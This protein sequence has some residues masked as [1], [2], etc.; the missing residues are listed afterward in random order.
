MGDLTLNLL[1]AVIVLNVGLS[2][3]YGFY[4]G[5]VNNSKDAVRAYLVD[6]GA[7]T[8]G[9]DAHFRYM[10]SVL[11]S[12]F[13][14]GGTIGTFGMPPI[15]D[16]IGR[17]RALLLCSLPCIA[18]C[19]MMALA[20]NW[21]MMISARLVVGFGL[22]GGLSVVN[23]YINEISPVSIRGALGTSTQL[24]ITIGI[25][26]SQALS[27]EKFHMLGTQEL[28]K[29]MMIAPALCNVL[30]VIGL[31][32]IP[33]SPSWLLQSQGEESALV[34]LRF[35]RTNSS[36]DEIQD[37]IDSLKNEAAL[38]H[39]KS[40]VTCREVFSDSRLW[41]PVIIGMFVNCSMQM[42]GIDSVFFYSSMVFEQAGIDRQSA[43][44][45]TTIVGVV[46]VLITIP[47]MLFMD[48]LG[49]KYIL[50]S[51][52]AGMCLSFMVSTYAMLNGYHMLAVYSMI[53]IIVFFA[54]GPGC[55]GWFI[56]SELSPMHARGFANALGLGANWGA[57]WLVGF[58]FPFILNAMGNWSFSVFATT[59]G[60][61]TVFTLL[62]VPETMG[63]K[64][65]E[66]AALFAP[67]GSTKEPLLA[68]A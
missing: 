16:K 48:K 5:F 27:T 9:D 40:T 8:A 36:E 4:L 10:W 29:Y 17:K 32:Y 13:A 56:V 34:A 59:T 53:A 28:W 54:F 14:I 58:L 18:C 64:P 2:F 47:A 31:L 57:N 15:T 1:I 63:L 51:G 42:S 7:E 37:E 52:L 65:E 33:D 61:L 25:A 43:Q 3:Q 66:V 23:M 46:N 41:K 62:C 45:W 49:R 24:L 21:T 67:K 39:G 55:I 50:A 22:G 12:I 60:V 30:L 68:D 26:G 19:A 35:L 44:V 11:V 38:S 20:T 6:L